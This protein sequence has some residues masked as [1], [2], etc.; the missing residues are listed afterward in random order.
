M[1][2]IKSLVEK[3]RS[4]DPEKIILFG[5]YAKGKSTPDSDVDLLIIKRT[6]KK[7]VERVGEVLKIVW[8][9]VP[10]IQPYVL[11]PAEFGKAIAE[12]KYFLT[13]EI[14]KHGKVIYEKE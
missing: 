13:K 2:D 3:L 5:S 12:R 14:L 11:T 9:N 6:N 1:L 4:L 10:H 8:G 7:P